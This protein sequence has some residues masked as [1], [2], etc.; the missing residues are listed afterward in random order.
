M[1]KNIAAYTEPNDWPAFISVNRTDNGDDISF[2]IRDRG[3]QKTGASDNMIEVFMP[4]Y[5]FI[6]FVEDL[7]KEFGE[8]RPVTPHRTGR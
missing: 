4:V 6:K 2:T 7:Q 5:D 1:S 8:G 3:N